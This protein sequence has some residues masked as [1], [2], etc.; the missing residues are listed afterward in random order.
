MA[1]LPKRSILVRT[2]FGD[3]H[4]WRSL[5]REIMTPSREGFL[6]YVTLVNDP[7]FAGLDP[8]AFRAKHPGGVNRPGESGDLSV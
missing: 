7:A 6:A 8:E 4:A 2:W 3:D 1:E 5:V